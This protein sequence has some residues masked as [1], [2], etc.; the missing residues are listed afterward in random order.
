MSTCDTDNYGRWDKRGTY[1]KLFD[2]IGLF[3]VNA[4]TKLDEH[5]QNL[6]V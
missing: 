2:D 6:L 4:L 5:Y 1:W 3:I